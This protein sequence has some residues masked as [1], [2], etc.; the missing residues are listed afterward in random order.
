M[1]AALGRHRVT[2]GKASLAARGREA[3]SMAD[4]RPRRFL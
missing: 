2:V 4:E 3:Q 1:E